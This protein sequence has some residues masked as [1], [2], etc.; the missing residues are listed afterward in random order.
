MYNFI[1]LPQLSYN[2]SIIRIAENTSIDITRLLISLETLGSNL[3]DY[4][5]FIDNN[6]TK[7]NLVIGFYNSKSSYVNIEI[8]GNQQQVTS[9]YYQED[10]IKYFVVMINK[11]GNCINFIR[12]ANNKICFLSLA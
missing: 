10:N 11:K 12:T 2:K 6:S 7:D 5:A 8:E 3:Y 9:N 4:F 1:P